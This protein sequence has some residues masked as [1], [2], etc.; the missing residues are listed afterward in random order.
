M[1]NLGYEQEDIAQE[2][3]RSSSSVSREIQRN[4]KANGEYE[5]RYAHKQSKLRRKRSKRGS[6]KIEND[7]N[8]SKRIEKRLHPLISPEVIAHDE[9]VCHESIYAWIYRSRPDLKMFLP[10]RGKKRRR[11]GSKRGKKQGWTQ[12]VRSIDV[13]FK[14]AN[15]RS[16]LRHF[17]GDT[18]RLDG[19]ALL[20]HTDRKSRFEIVHLIPNET[21]NQAYVNVKSDHHLKK[22]KSITY[23]RGSTFADWRMIERATGTKI[24]FAH[25]HHPWERGTNENHNQRLRRVFPKGSKYS[26]IKKRDLAKVVWIMNHTKRKCLNWCTPCEVYGGCC[27]SR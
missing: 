23:D 8:L 25:A 26:S 15:N 27:T 5:P 10:Q 4:S 9:K 11:Y 16:R 13:R 6:R 7:I 17:E 19:G 21:A 2:L 20:T 14:G 1:L 3:K 12:N 24:F 22:A 18:V